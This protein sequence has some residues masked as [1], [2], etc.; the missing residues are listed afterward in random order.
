MARTGKIPI[1]PK[2]PIYVKY[3]EV[4]TGSSDGSFNY[5]FPSTLSGLSFKSGQCNIFSPTPYFVTLN[6]K[7]STGWC[8][9]IVYDKAGNRVKNTA[10]NVT[11][12]G[13]YD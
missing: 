11:L 10:F 1:E 9:F 6:N 13:Y 8:N 4:T 12:I 3:Q 7:N 2:I 5:T